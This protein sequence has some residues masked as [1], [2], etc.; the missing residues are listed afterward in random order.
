MRAAAPWRPEGAALRGAAAGVEAAA[1][2]TPIPGV[3]N[4]ASTMQQLLVQQY[5]AQANAQQAGAEQATDATEQGAKPEDDVVDAEF[6]E[7]KDDKK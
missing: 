5:L 7:V 1:S 2:G 4:I 3:T 6:E